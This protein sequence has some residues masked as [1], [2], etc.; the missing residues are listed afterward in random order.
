MF[1]QVIPFHTPVAES[2]KCVNLMFD[3]SPGAAFLSHSLEYRFYLWQNAIEVRKSFKFQ[4]R[5]PELYLCLSFSGMV[6]PP[7]PSASTALHITPGK[8]LVSNFSERGVTVRKGR[9]W[10][11]SVTQTY[12]L[13]VIFESLGNRQRFRRQKISSPH[14]NQ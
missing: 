13:V 11:G 8:I 14:D 7:R 5:F 2:Y 1:S 3:R 10:F 12:L 6:Y 4:F 9:M